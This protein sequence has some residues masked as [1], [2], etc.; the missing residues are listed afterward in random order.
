MKTIQIFF[1]ECSGPTLKKHSQM[2][3]GIDK[4]STQDKV[5]NV[6]WDLPNS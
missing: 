4:Y 5:M 6:S 1:K 2:Y 3:C